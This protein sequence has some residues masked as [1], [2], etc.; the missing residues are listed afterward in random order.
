MILLRATNL[1]AAYEGRRIF[2]GIDLN[3]G[4]G[5]YALVGPNGSGKSTLLRLLAGGQLPSAGSVAIAGY[6]LARSP[7]PAR[8]ALSYV[9]DDMPAYPFM[10]GREFL[11]F[12]AS[13]KAVS[14]G[15]TVEALI[16]VFALAQ[17][18][19]QRVGAISLGTQ[20][21]L[22]LAAGWIGQPQLLLLDEP[23]NALDAIARDALIER[24]RQDRA[25]AVILFASHDAEFI[26]A[27]GATT[28]AMPALLAA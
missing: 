2:A 6:D 13:A 4:A 15:V 26:E 5:A 22:L 23:S 20:K 28:I 11:S 27:T 3:L 19:D 7:L 8:R 16:D 10:T 12:V 14:L 17:H 21:K 1:A 24:I 25:H 18:L 9:P